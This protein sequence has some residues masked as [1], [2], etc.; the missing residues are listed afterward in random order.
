MPAQ[1]KYQL[2][3]HAVA[4][5]GSAAVQHCRHLTVLWVTCDGQPVHVVDEIHVHQHSH[6]HPLSGGHVTSS[7][8]GSELHLEPPGGLVVLL[9]QGRRAVVGREPDHSLGGSL[10]ETLSRHRDATPS[11]C[12][13]SQWIT[14]VQLIL[15]LF[16]CKFL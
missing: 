2:R 9:H 16:K 14:L 15:K 4:M 11:N 5:I 12:H 6:C 8:A 10:G 1:H 13:F 3:S 7:R